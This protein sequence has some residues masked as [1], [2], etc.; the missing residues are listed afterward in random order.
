VAS[1]LAEVAGYIVSSYRE[2]ARER[3]PSPISMVIERI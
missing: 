3:T 1:I 2:H